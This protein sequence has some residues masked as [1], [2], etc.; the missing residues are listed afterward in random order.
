MPIA[1][2]PL[3]ETEDEQPPAPE[4]LGLALSGGGYRA[5]LFH[6]GSLWRMRDAGLLRYVTRVS[7]VSGG[8]IIAARL[9]LVWHRIDWDDQGESFRRQLVDP[10]RQLAGETVDWVAAAEGAL[11]FTTVGHQLAKAYGKHLLGDATLQDLPAD[12]EG[13][14]FVINATNL[15]SAA[16][17]RF[18]KAY[19]GDYRVGLAERPHLPLSWAVAASSGYPPIL[20]PFEL[21]GREFEFKPVKGADL[22]QPGYTRDILLSDGGVYDNLGL[23]PLWRSC[24]RLLVSDGGGRLAAEEKPLNHMTGQMGRVAGVIDNQVRSL[25]KRMLMAA[26]KDRHDSADYRGGAYWSIRTKAENYGV[27]SMAFPPQRAGQLAAIET[28]LAAL[29]D[30]D[31]MDLINWGYA[32]CDAALRSHVDTSMPIGHWPYPDD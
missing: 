11:P 21:D 28:R 30:E 15:Q 22:N 6:A 20:S 12:G 26:Y 7:S 3:I 14:R 31:Q 16:L 9:G 1:L 23:E 17:W 2:T 25:R 18:S 19:M 10:I 29:P 5:M 8:S 4:S 27:P 13:P 24:A 32:I